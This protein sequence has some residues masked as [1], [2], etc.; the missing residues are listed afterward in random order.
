M[1]LNESIAVSTANVLLVPYDRRH[2]PTYHAWMEDPAIQEATASERLTLDE[3]YENQES[4]RVSHDK[5]TFIV[6]QPLAPVATAAATTVVVAGS[7]DAPDTM[8]GDVNLFVYPY[9]DDDDSQ[10]E[11]G[12]KAEPL[13]VVG[14]I[15][16]MIAESRNR[17]RGVGRA[18]V[19]AFLNYVSR[20]LESILHE[21][22][23]DSGD[24][25]EAK[26]QQQQQQQSTPRLKVL[27]AKINEGNAKSIALF[28]SLGFEQEGQVNYFGELK[29]VLRDLD[30]AISAIAPEGYVEL[31]YARETQETLATP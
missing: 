30:K 31:S 17:G 21:F 1:K 3:E 15:D 8:V 5:L 26:Q 2:V 9:D 13:Y 12:E 29:L 23:C 19:L 22:G 28:R 11:G 18:A 16:I 25:I 27:M 6:C 24:A 14:E 20:N 4:W 10:S 7:A